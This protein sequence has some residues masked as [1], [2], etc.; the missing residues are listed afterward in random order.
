M[1]PLYDTDLFQ[2]INSTTPLCP[3]KDDSTPTNHSI[4]NITEPHIFIK[5][6]IRWEH[7]NISQAANQI[8][9]SIIN[10]DLHI[11]TDGAYQQD[12]QQGA[13]ALVFSTG[14][15]NILWKGSGPSLG[16]PVAMTPYRAELSGLT[17]CLCILH[18]ICM[19]EAVNSGKVT[20]Y[21]D[22]ETA[23]REVFAS[24]RHTNNPYK[25]LQADI[26]LLSYARQLVLHLS[27]RITVKKEWVKGHFN[28]PNRQLKHD[29]NDLADNLAGD[30]NFLKRA[31]AHHPPIVPPL[32]EAELIHEN[33][34]VTS[35][36]QQIVVSSLHTKPLLQ[37]IA[38]SA[39]WE[40]SI[41]EKIDWAAHKR[42][43]HQF[44][45]TSRIGVTKHAHALY[46]TNKKANQLYGTTD[47]CP[48]CNVN[49]ENLA[50]VFSCPATEARQH[51]N[52]MREQLEA[53]LKQINTP[54]KIVQAMIQGLQQ[55]EITICSPTGSY[56]APF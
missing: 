49:V 21:C 53:R 45:G 35:K 7:S 10:E 32:Y 39:N 13:Q 31:R 55:W 23:L 48:C 18:W 22:N 42:A 37:Y 29:L 51:R 56:K 1:D 43:I 24:P 44:T 17:S 36:L 50:H 15:K 6:L 26:D 47:L 19:T 14:T 9:Q 11:C 27:A 38:K 3:Q 5:H 34:I 30:Y 20:I 41:L 54:P 8:A 40:Q 25:Q 33:H 12:S 2:S 46:H 28:G 52:T 16:H 4:A